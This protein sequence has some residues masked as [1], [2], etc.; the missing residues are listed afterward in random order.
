MAA[1]Q[2]QGRLLRQEANT[3]RTVDVRIDNLTAAE[4]QVQT[5]AVDTRHGNAYRKRQSIQDQVDAVI[6][7]PTALAQLLDELRATYGRSSTEV[8]TRTI[9]TTD[10]SATIQIEM[11]P[12][13]VWL[14][15]LTE[16]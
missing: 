5:F 14:V 2:K 7:N 9:N 11:E 8:E 12:N 10:G 13:S 6:N 3:N 15:L 16:S 1:I 4:Y